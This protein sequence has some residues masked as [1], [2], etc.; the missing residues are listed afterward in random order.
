MIIVYENMLK[1]IGIGSNIS[2]DH[3][4]KL[5]LHMSWI[6]I[7]N[8]IMSPSMDHRCNKVTHLLCIFKC[9]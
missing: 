1:I 6:V 9:K 4:L 7:F 5:A 3:F 8:K 2:N